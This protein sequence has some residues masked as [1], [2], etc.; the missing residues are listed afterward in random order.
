MWRRVYLLLLLFRLYFALSPSY[1]HPDENFQGPEVIAGSVF[2][3]PVH[4][5]WEFT[6]EFPIRSAVPLWLV[7]GLPMLILRSL[8]GGLRKDTLPPAIVY[9][10]LRG[11]MFTLSF[12]LEDWALLELVHSRKHR[13]IAVILTASSYVTWSYQT[14]TFSNS[15]ET[16]LVLWSLVL[17]QRII[18]KRER[19]SALICFVLAFLCVLGVFNR[20]TFPAYLLVPGLRLFPHFTRN[21]LSFIYLGLFG[22]MFAFLAVTIDTSY[23]RPSTTTFLEVIRDPIITPLNNLLYNYAPENLA[24]HGLHPFYQHFVANL[25]QLLGPAFILFVFYF[26]RSF[27]L[28]S[29]LSAVIVLSLF[30]HQEARFLIP[31]VPLILSSIKLPSKRGGLLK[32]WVASWVIFNLAMGILMG[33]YHQGGVVPMQMHIAQEDNINHAFW[34]KTYS[35]PIW[36]LDG[37]ISDITTTDFMGAP[38]DHVLNSIDKVVKCNKK[39]Q[40]IVLVA[41]AAMTALDLLHAEKVTKGIALTQRWKY[42]SHI[43]LDDLDFDDGVFPA[44]Q[45][46]FG[47]TGL[48]LWDVQKIC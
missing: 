12:V 15:V 1:L 3:Y 8:W 28:Y 43:S 29:A 20:I 42:N 16:L 35:P 48:V 18:S 25:P 19:S 30:P 9:W 6:S 36:L 37:K 26:R 21:P 39:N 11:L 24:K 32:I 46:L 38:I 27:R 31:A 17:I 47:R 13:T 5:T 23:Y 10:T 45:R 7:Y 41:P 14:H 44:L 22:S 33:T 2:S 34:W 4:H 40:G